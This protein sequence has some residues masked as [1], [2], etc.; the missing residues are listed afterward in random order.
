MYVLLVADDTNTCVCVCVYGS[1]S[2]CVCDFFIWLVVSMWLCLCVCVCVCECVSVCGYWTYAR[3][4]R[5]CLYGPCVLWA[6]M[7]LYGC[8]HVSGSMRAQCAFAVRYV[9]WCD[10]CVWLYILHYVWC[11]DTYTDTHTLEN[12][13]SYTCMRSL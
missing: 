12:S 9:W 10:T 3:I 6:Q 7:A 2:V 11:Y 4:E 8:R 1:H 13:Y 5:L